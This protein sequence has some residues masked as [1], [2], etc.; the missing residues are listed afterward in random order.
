MLNRITIGRYCYGTSKI[1]NWNPIIKLICSLIF[2][3]SVFLCKGWI[4]ISFLGIL[5]SLLLL[6][7][8][9]SFIY[10][11]K[12]IWSI[13]YFL[14]FFFVFNL[15][16]QVPLTK[17]VLLMIQMIMVVLYSVMVLY[18]TSIRNLIY[19]FTYFLYPLSWV[20][21]PIFSLAQVLGLSISFLPIILFQ[22][23][24]IMKS[25]IARGIDYQNSTL[26]QKFEVIK[27]ILFPLLDLSFEYADK[28]S[29]TM[30][31]RL[32]RTDEKSFHF[33]DLSISFFDLFQLVLHIL[34]FILILKEGVL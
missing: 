2:V 15:L 33:Q 20:G 11:W 16:F 25:L 21:I 22:T 13:R 10:Y 9:I 32:Y 7:S 34:I 30:E 28:V 24:K 31:V 17:D 12:C 29:D 14:V 18:T 19:S 6:Q 5:L 27:I 4:S 23:S 1:H 8:A 3:F 26:R